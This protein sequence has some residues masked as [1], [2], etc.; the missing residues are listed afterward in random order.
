M[1]E[2]KKASRANH[3][4]SRDLDR[5]W[6]LLEAGELAQAHRLAEGLRGSTPDSPDVLLLL[7]ACARAQ[8]QDDEALEF[9][10]SAIA[11]DP[12]WAEPELFAAEL[13]AEREQLQ[14]ALAHAQR[15]L[16][17]A[18][19]EEPVGPDRLNA[20]ALTAGLQLDLELAGD[21]RETLSRL[22]P[23]VDAQANPD[24]ARE[25]AQLFLELDE[26][27]AAR[28]WFERAVTLDEQDAD[29]WHGIG[30]AAELTGD[31]SGKRKA[32][33]QTLDL[34]ADQDRELPELLSE[35][36]TADVAESALAEL[37]AG[38]R[39]LLANIPILI[40]D[41]PARADVET[42][43]DPRLLGLFAGTAYP[44]VSSLGGTPHLTQILLFRRNLER[45]AFDEDE[46]KAE[47]RTTL[48]H[49]TGH[50]FGLDE[51][52]LHHIGLG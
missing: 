14:E 24:V 12:N 20:L 41:R 3:R 19:S 40:A 52:D 6:D 44:E 48:L 37:P 13:L 22:P 46:L 34:D 26:A 42:G 9:L 39:R 35:K 36:Q 23:A 11:L 25:I 47:I 43:L 8:E 16:N 1:K 5:A 2:P 50:F 21:A 17:K 4:L 18:E 33:L 7:A 10:E 32:W 31:E 45:V 49:E 28:V 51:D 29:A 27:A 30:L 15:G 38:A